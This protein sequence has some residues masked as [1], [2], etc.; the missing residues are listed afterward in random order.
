MSIMSNKD[1]PADWNPAIFI[2]DAIAKIRSLVQDDQVILGLS[3]GVDSSVAAAL[4]HRAITDQLL[5]IFVDNGCMRFQEAKR[6][7]QYFAPLS[8]FQIH[9]VDASQLFLDRLKGVEDPETKRKIIGSTFIDVFEAE[10]IKH[11][12]VR[13]LAQGTV[14][15]DVIESQT[16]DGSGAKVKSHHNVGGLPE[17]MKLSLL[18][19]LRDLYKE[20]VREVGRALGLPSELVDRHPFPGPGLAVRILG[21]VT[22]QKLHILQQVDEI[23]IQELRTQNLYHAT[24][25]AFAVLLP[26]RSVGVKDGM[27]SYEYVC[28]L[29]A[30]NS[31]DGMTANWTPLPHSF[32]K[33]VSSRILSE[34]EGINRVVFDISDKPPATIEWE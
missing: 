17:R 12:N 10:S 4:I 30:V 25:Q 14:R 32:L 7:A 16:V 33:T 34:V 9:F 31:S 21:E 15:S 23:Y 27:R 3:G 29:R 24:W 26:I 20:Q 19:P 11:P 1:I 2:E 5:P 6:V 13:W 22:P 18:E 28:A 8:A